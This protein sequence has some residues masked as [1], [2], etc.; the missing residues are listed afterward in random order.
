MTA[1][2]G[3]NRQVAKTV[4]LKEVAGNREI[5]ELCERIPIDEM[6]KV[7]QESLPEE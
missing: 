3:V 1:L 6:A 4:G 2:L 7:I 5:A